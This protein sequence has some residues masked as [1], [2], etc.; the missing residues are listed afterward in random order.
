MKINYDKT[1]V[2]RVGPISLSE[3][4]LICHWPLKWEKQ[5]TILGVDFMSDYQDMRK[6]NFDRLIQNVRPIIAVWSL[7]SLTVLGN[8][9]S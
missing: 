7:R 4:R 9:D 1:K 3:D 8:I 6:V 2:L 5:V